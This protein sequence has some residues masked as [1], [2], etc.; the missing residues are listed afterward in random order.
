MNLREI[1]TWIDTANDVT[2]LFPD[3]IGNI[4]AEQISGFNRY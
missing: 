3:N 2:R 4:V 1:V